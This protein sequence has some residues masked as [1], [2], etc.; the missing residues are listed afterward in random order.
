MFRALPR[1]LL[2]AVC[3][4]LHVPDAVDFLALVARRPEVRVPWPAVTRG[5][6]PTA[7]LVENDYT[8][9]YQAVV[10]RCSPALLVTLEVILNKSSLPWVN[11]LLATSTGLQRL[12]LFVSGDDRVLLELTSPLLVTDLALSFKDAW[13]TTNEGLMKTLT[14]VP[15]LKK[16]LLEFYPAYA[17]APPHWVKQALCSLVPGCLETLGLRGDVEDQQCLAETIAECQPNLRRLAIGVSSDNLGWLGC[18]E[19][20][21]VASFAA[22]D[23][24]DLRV[25]ESLKRLRAVDVWAENNSGR[26]L[27]LPGTVTE[28]ACRCDFLAPVHLPESLEVLAVC[29]R[30]E[31][32]VKLVAVLPTLSGLRNLTLNLGSGRHEARK[33]QTLLEEASFSCPNVERLVLCRFGTCSG[34]FWILKSFRGLRELKFEDWHGRGDRDLE[35]KSMFDLCPGLQTVRDAQCGSTVTVGRRD[36]GRLVRRERDAR[37]FL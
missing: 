32:V 37:A 3:A 28:F 27:S 7:C 24:A 1:D 26:V 2:A 36:D 13:V 11:A 30:P 6:V 18:L 29:V 17:D 14:R 35:L 10:K 8:V 19:L 5:S 15:A 31:D 34:L 23:W 33:A 9:L 20:L 4:M 21:E 12:G 25:I 22:Y 16:L